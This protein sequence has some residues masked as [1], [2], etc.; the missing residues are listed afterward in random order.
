MY[1]LKITW[2]SRKCEFDKY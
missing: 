1:K 2:N